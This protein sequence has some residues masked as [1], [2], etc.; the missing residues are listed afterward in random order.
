MIAAYSQVLQTFQIINLKKTKKQITSAKT[1]EPPLAGTIE[2]VQQEIGVV[3]I[4]GH[5]FAEQHLSLNSH[6]IK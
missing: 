2:I 1:T 4:N 3:N 5:S 6:F